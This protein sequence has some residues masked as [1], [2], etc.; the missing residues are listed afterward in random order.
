MTKYYIIYTRRIAAA[1]R[2][3][4]FSIV[5]VGVNPNKPEFDCYYFEDSKEFQQALSELTRKIRG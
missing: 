3:M 1:L 5:K 4:G 2:E